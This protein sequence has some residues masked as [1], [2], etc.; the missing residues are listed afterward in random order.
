MQTTESLIYI[1]EDFV[2]LWRDEYITIK[3]GWV[4]HRKISKQLNYN[5][6]LI[7]LCEKN[8]GIYAWAPEFA[9][10]HST[11]PY[12]EKPIVVK[13]E[14][15]PHSEGYFQAMKSFGNEEWNHVRSRIKQSDPMMCWSIGQSCRL[16]PDWEN[17]KDEVMMEALR[18]KFKDPFLENLLLSTGGMP[19]VQLKQC[20]YW[21]SGK[22]GNGKNM[23]GVLLQKLRKE[24]KY[25]KI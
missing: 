9:N 12:E 5:T 11:F 19:I 23:L 3:K 13:G 10:V 21:G 1:R 20:P 6:R 25:K 14:I 18:S 2:R 8:Y 15:W 4:S 16:R 24:I 17:I 22:Y 7:D